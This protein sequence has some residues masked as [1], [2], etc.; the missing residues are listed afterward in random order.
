[1]RRRRRNC[2]NGAP[3]KNAWLARTCALLGVR[4][5]HSKPYSPE[6]RGKQERLNSYIR[7][8]FLEE[9]CHK[10]IESLAALNDYF[11]AWEEEVC[12]KRVHAETDERP[13]ERF[14]RTAPHAQADPERLA[15]AFRWSVVRKV[16]RTAT[17]SLEG[18]AYSVDPVLV[19]RRIE[20][21]YHP[22]DLTTIDVFFDGRAAGLAVP[23]RIGRHSHKAVPQA[24]RPAPEPTG[25]D[26]LEMVQQAHEE[27]AGTGA[28]LDYARLAS[29]RRDGEESEEE[30]R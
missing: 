9:A 19:S 3:F 7:E 15:E 20:L 22:E 21:R 1:L 28:K 11:V 4:L 17:V 27:S 26:F 18:N 5:V 16:S 29:S 23:F 2:D 12:N 14:M 24:E 6:G 8:G 13:I 30:V 25:I 10:G